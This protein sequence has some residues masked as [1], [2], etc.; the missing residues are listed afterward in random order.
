MKVNNY[1]AAR[2]FEYR[3]ASK[4]MTLMEILVSVA[5]IGLVFTLVSQMISQ[6]TKNVGSSMWHAERLKESQLFFKM[7]REDLH[8]ASDVVSVDYTVTDP[9]NELSISKKQL[10]YS[11]PASENFVNPFSNVN[12]AVNLKVAKSGASNQTVMSFSINKLSKRNST[13]AST[14][15][16]TIQ[17][18]LELKDGVLTYT[19]Q[20]I[21]GTPEAQDDETLIPPPGKAVLSDVDFIHISH[22]DTMSD[23][24]SPPRKI[25]SVVNFF[26]RIKAKGDD[27][28]K[29]EFK[30][31]I[32]TSIEAVGT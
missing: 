23:F 24:Y 28:K 14:P 11:C 29:A 27:N 8:K 1:S 7:L 15:G 10:V 16:Y 31:S 26:V 22:E 9:N 32:K 18:K 25:G 20:L 21:S 6:G 12:A 13:G 2:L 30:Q 17:V 19:K 3:N 5:I 4:A